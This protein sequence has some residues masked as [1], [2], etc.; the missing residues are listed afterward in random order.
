MFH[1]AFTK[2]VSSWNNSAANLARWRWK[3]TP[4][5]S[6]LTNLSLSSLC[7]SVLLFLLAKTFFFHP[8]TPTRTHPQEEQDTLTG[9]HTHTHTVC[10]LSQLMKQLVRCPMCWTDGSLP[11]HWIAPNRRAHSSAAMIVLMDGDNIQS[12]VESSR[13]R[14]DGCICLWWT[15]DACVFILTLVCVC[16]RFAP[17]F[18]FN[19]TASHRQPFEFINRQIRNVYVCPTGLS[20]TDCFHF[21]F[22]INIVF[23]CFDFMVFT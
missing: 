1:A 19:T 6:L 20:I 11:V 16:S 10:V 14:V 22:L 3:I 4:S 21:M 12:A 7:C 9:A 5:V 13:T 23:F 2:V 15:G 17:D 18:S 8:F